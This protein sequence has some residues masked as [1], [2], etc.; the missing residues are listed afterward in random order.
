MGTQTMPDYIQVVTTTS[1]R[2]E[3]D[4]IAF[5][6]IEGRLAACVQVL[7]PIRS[8]YRWQDKI[9]VAEEWQCLAKSRREL[10]GRIEEAIRRYHSYEVPE[11]L[12]IPILAAS[13]SYLAWLDGQV[14]L[15][16]A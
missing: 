4:R 7:G 5:A 14:D 3:A 15:S 16:L 12:A 8:T 6:L 11:I 1:Q 13:P 9:E 2:V 10:Y